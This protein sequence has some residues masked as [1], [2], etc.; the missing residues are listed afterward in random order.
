[1]LVLLDGLEFYV[2]EMDRTE[3]RRTGAK[4]PVGCNPVEPTGC[5]S[6]FVA[7]EQD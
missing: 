3:R 7:F 4:A 5:W 6:T 2:L 1:M